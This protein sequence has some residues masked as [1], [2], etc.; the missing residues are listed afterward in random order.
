MRRQPCRGRWRDELLERYA[1]HVG[2]AP[3]YP[4]RW[5]CSLAV[6]PLLQAAQAETARQNGVLCLSC[7]VTLGRR[8][9]VHVPARDL[10]RCPGATIGQEM[11]SAVVMSRNRPTGKRCQV[12][13]PGEMVGMSRVRWCFN[14]AQLN[15][16][17]LCVAERRVQ[18]STHH[19]VRCRKRPPAR[20]ALPSARG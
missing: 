6:K 7:P 9:R 16:S 12:M 3:C 8:E 2:S 13:R 1:I 15:V 18:F 4:S 10:N 20:R 5:S 14:R 17:T 19:L 11:K